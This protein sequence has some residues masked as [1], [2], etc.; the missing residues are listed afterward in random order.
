MKVNLPFAHSIL[1]GQ[2]RV[3][4]IRMRNGLA[5]PIWIRT[6]IVVI[7][8]DFVQKYVQFAQANLHRSNLQRRFSAIRVH[9]EFSQGADTLHGAPPC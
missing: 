5:F 7:L 8:L 6:I 2:A 1:V 9:Q 4:G 3:L